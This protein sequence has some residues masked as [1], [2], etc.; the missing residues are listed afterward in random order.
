MAD[1]KIK[2]DIE[3]AV[4]GEADAAKLAKELRNVGDVLEGDLQKSALDA[5]Q[6]LES[7]GAKQR[8]LSEFARLKR[9]AEDMA[10]A[11]GTATKVVNDLGNELPQASANTQALAGAERA[12]TSALAEAQASLARKKEALKQLREE[13]TGAARR[14][15]EFK[16][17]E[18]G[19][20]T[21]IAAT[22]AEV[23]TRKTDLISTTQGLAQATAAEAALNKEYQLAI[24]VAAK[25]SA[26][27]GN[28]TRALEASRAA[29]NAAGISTANLVQADRNLQAAV[30]QVRDRVSE[31]APAYQR[32]AAASSASTQA[33]AQNQRTLRDG[34]ADIGAQLQR[35]Q[36]I[37]TVALGGSYVGGLAKSVADT[38]DEFR[39]LQARIELVTGEGEALQT[40][41][42]GVTRVALDTNTTLSATGDLFFRLAK[43]AQEGGASAEAA[44]Q[45]A[46]QLVQTINQTV[47]LSGSTAA[48]SNAAI[49]QLIQGLQSGVLRGEEFNSIMEQAPRLAEALAK[50]L[51][52]TT[53]G[54]RDMANQGQLTA[55]VVMKALQGQSDAVAKEFDKL[56]PT[57][58]RAL[59]NLTTAWTLYV[60]ESDKGLVSSAN[61]AKAINALAQNL[62]VLVTS[63]TSAGKLW[64]AI[65]IA[66]LAAD[67][68]RWATQMLTATT[69]VEANTLATAGNTAAQTANAAAQAQ[70]VAAQTAGTAA[71][72]A[73]TAAQSANAA[74][75][76]SIATFTGQA[77]AA[78]AAATAATAAGT[79][80]TVAKTAQMGL[81]G[82]AVG[83]VTSLLGG[84]V[85]LTVAAALFSSEIKAG[86]VSVTEWAA[87]FTEAGKRLKENEQKLKEVEAAEKRA[88]LARQE[89]AEANKAA[90]QAMLGLTKAGDALVSK[91]D[92]LRKSGK[93]SADAI[94]DI[95]KDFDLSTVPGIRDAGTVLN[96]LLQKGKITAQEFEGAW[97]QALK[98]EDLSRFE[99]N[100]KAAF[101]GVA[102]AAERLAQITDQ[103]LREAVRRVGPEYDL[104][105][106]AINKASAGA[107][108]D[109]QAM[110]NGLDRLRTQGVNVAAALTASLGRGID[111]ANTIQALE[112]VK[113]QI[114]QVRKVLGDKVADGLL[115]QAAT[116]AD[117]LKKKIE[118]I[119]PGIQS[120]QEAMR[121]LGI[122]SDAELKKVAASSQSAFDTLKTSG[123][124]SARELAAAFAKSAQDAI[125]ANNGIAPSWVTAQAAANGYKL[126]LDELGKTTLV[127][128]KSATD[129]NTQSANDLAAAHAAGAQAAREWAQAQ[130]DAGAAARAAKLTDAEL[131]ADLSGDKYGNRPGGLPARNA[132]LSEDYKRRKAKGQDAE[133]FSVD[134]SGKRVEAVGSSPADMMPYIVGQGMDPN[135]PAAM[136][137]AERLSKRVTDALKAYTGIGFS[138]G[139]PKT[140]WQ[141]AAEEA[142]GSVGMVA[143]PP[144][145]S[146][147][148]ESGSTFDGPTVAPAPS[149]APAQR[150]VAAKTY[151]V[152]L[153]GSTARFDS[154]AEAQAFIAQLRQA[155]LSA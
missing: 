77:A 40:S 143:S 89:G 61:A 31:L 41:W 133:G 6:A 27:V 93:S 116:A 117:L 104:L 134:A 92:E 56:P 114:E 149:P 5:A 141:M 69:A 86:I 147:G 13:T 36:Q 126:V 105:A 71:T 124:A 2:Y 155:R 9:E 43:A 16:A 12:M 138:G 144:S 115:Q 11:L 78:T 90:E 64:A 107:I 18:T 39:N 4:S 58:G 62:D 111:T 122:T 67:F 150:A 76:G 119:A 87:S 100:A 101:A 84:P 8:S 14:T 19:L 81:L 48:A 23:K 132:A 83:G 10:A 63:L 113:A 73:H 3:A 57:V 33:Q 99:T 49:V 140:I 109:T 142:S 91:F 121:Q 60:G 85:G 34:M 30:S 7:L 96:A 148:R 24:G 151:N 59:Q 82:R 52:V 129:G 103:A 125:D 80:A 28:R 20:K 128:L 26:E 98:G 136:A 35:I 21:A 55:E 139:P 38:A 66:G 32:A 37:A 70:R 42:A 102:G 15:D 130:T 112:A 25:A 120:A 153:G 152:Q 44:Q 106:G 46:L 94:A 17:A 22:T 29:L 45:R 108:N 79:A 47:Q 97:A 65:K 51:G 118:D 88:S 135:D 127:N 50:G 123:T 54:L 72:V 110:I 154:D 74:A 68:G 1:P 137:A 131:E 95:G 75:W 146:S 145:R 53:G